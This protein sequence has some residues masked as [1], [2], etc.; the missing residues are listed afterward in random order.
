MG[1]KDEY[2]VV[3]DIKEQELLKFIEE[4][5]TQKGKFKIVSF[6]SKEFEK[7]KKVDN[8]IF[9]YPKDSKSMVTTLQKMKSDNPEFVATCL[10][11]CDKRKDGQNTISPYM[12][13]MDHLASL[14][15]ESS[16]LVHPAFINAST[17]NVYGKNEPGKDFMKENIENSLAYLVKQLDNAYN[18]SQDREL[19][20]KLSYDIKQ[21]KPGKSPALDVFSTFLNE[22]RREVNRSTMYKDAYTSGHISR[23]TALSSALGQ[24]LE[25]SDEDAQVLEAMALMHDI[26]KIITPTEVLKYQGELR[27]DMKD[28]MSAH[29]DLG[30]KLFISMLANYYRDF[31][32]GKND[33]KMQEF[34]R[35]CMQK[36]GFRMNEVKSIDELL[37][38]LSDNNLVD[39]S[40]K[41]LINDVYCGVSQ[42]HT[43]ESKREN[44]QSGVETEEEIKKR[45][46]FVDIIQVADSTDAATSDRGYNFPKTL[47][48]LACDLAGG[49]NHGNYDKDAVAAFISYLTSQPVEEAKKEIEFI[50]VDDEGKPAK[51]IGRYTRSDTRG[52][53]ELGTY[54]GMY[55]QRA[56]KGTNI[57]EILIPRVKA[58]V[59]DYES[60]DDEDKAKAKTKVMQKILLEKMDDELKAEVIKNC[61]EFESLEKD[62]KELLLKKKFFEI[63][64]TK[65]KGR[66]KESVEAQIQIQKSWEH[67]DK[68]N[69]GSKISSSDI[70]F[71]AMY[72]EKGSFMTTERIARELRGRISKEPTDFFSARDKLVYEA[73]LELLPEKEQ[74][75]INSLEIEEQVNQGYL[76]LEVGGSL[77][78][79]ISQAIYSKKPLGQKYEVKSKEEIMGYDMENSDSI[80]AQ[81]D[82]S[83]I[84]QNIFE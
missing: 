13:G 79:G 11:Y 1:R 42:H 14:V 84:E 65:I 82:K 60:L 33:R 34:D 75:E 20:S 53:G 76:K 19:R 55:L 48:A 45:N 9:E 39:D 16:V 50:G 69:P 35:E 43:K 12:E 21:M 80:E 77:V 71:D 5:Y 36:Y 32:T 2:V 4:Y 6:G 8:F 56:E 26:G 31:K 37:N 47:S 61:P 15:A 40:V 44:V 7:L 78:Y 24:K 38:I 68:F 64:S 3:C 18:V 74:E 28:A 51:K 23:V 54:I 57:D 30:G 66:V 70:L 41:K 67:D 72:K 25:L 10:D 58:A 73:C 29:D 17:D 59:E 62:E 83:E 49:A 63:V 81:K 27:G 46:L 22:V 52:I